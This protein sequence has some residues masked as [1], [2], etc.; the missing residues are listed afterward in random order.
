M[1]NDTDCENTVVR[2]EAQPAHGDGEAIF[3][4][5]LGQQNLA[6]IVEELRG[7]SDE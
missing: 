5:L 3:N 1:T 2:A 4:S 7:E 6:E